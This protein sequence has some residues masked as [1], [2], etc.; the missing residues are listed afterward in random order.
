VAGKSHINRLVR[1]IGNDARRIHAHESGKIRLYMNRLLINPEIVPISVEPFSRVMTS[2]KADRGG[3]KANRPS[4][5]IRMV[6]F[7]MKN[8]L[9][10]FRDPRRQGV[11]MPS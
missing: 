9:A 4:K 1:R 10:D 6:I 2:Q 5:I 7:F 8:L 11:F 3:K